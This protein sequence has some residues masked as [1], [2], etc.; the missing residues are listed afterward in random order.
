MTSLWLFIFPIRI[1]IRI[2]QSEVRIRG[3][4]SASGFV[5]KCHWSP[6]LVKS[7]FLRA[8]RAASVPARA[9]VCGDQ[10]CADAAHRIQRHPDPAHRQGKDRGDTGTG[11]RLK[12]T[13]HEINIFLNPSV[14][15]TLPSW[16]LECLFVFGNL[17]T[18][19]LNFW[20]II[21]KNEEKIFFTYFSTVSDRTINT[22]QPE[23]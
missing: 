1:R 2:R 17:R 12:G 23:N 13:C 19:Y 8:G 11:Y 21:L 6:T 7:T 22:V 5:P 16:N 10:L 20:K 3:S 15:T 9:L 4:G 18:L 14:L